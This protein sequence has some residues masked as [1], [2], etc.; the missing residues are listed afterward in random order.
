[1]LRETE[2]YMCM[3]YVWNSSQDV[4]NGTLDLVLSLFTHTNAVQTIVIASKGWWF[5]LQYPLPQTDA[6]P[7]RLG[8]GIRQVKSTV[9]TGSRSL[10]AGRFAAIKRS[11]RPPKAANPFF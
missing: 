4:E 2:P 8:L 11:A 6:S 7:S 9:K 10:A 3:P 5:F 1:M